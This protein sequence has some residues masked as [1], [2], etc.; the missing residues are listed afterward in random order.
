[1]R[2]F[3]QL[4]L[5]AAAMAAMAAGPALASTIN[6]IKMT[7][8]SG[9]S[10]VSGLTYYTTSSNAVGYSN[11]DF[12][13][14]DIYS[15]FGGNSN[16]PTVT[17]YG[18]NLSGTVAAC[19]IATGCAPLTVMISD[20]G[21][22]AAAASFESSL[23]NIETGAGSVTQ[24][25]YYDATDTYFGPGDSGGMIIGI[26]L[27]LSGSGYD[28]TTGL[29]PIA[30]GSAYSL[31][32]VDTFSTSCASSGCASFTVGGEISDPPASTVPEPGTLAL[33]GAG[34]LGFALVMRRRA[35]QRIDR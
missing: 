22:T 19:E 27:T 11:P 26:P 28:S 3:F 9:G 16:S 18:I 20:T 25:A 31:T 7:L 1:M 35:R 8:S 34:L 4:G 24:Q 32:L 10:T 29:G 33:F 5:A 17:P 14:W 21:F 2:R 6:P 15:Q 23:T 30:G 13:G 12:N